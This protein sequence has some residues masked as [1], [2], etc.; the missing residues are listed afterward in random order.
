MSAISKVSGNAVTAT[1]DALAAK[2]AAAKA[3]EAKDTPSAMQD[4]SV[5]SKEVVAEKVA[6]TVEASNATKSASIK[7]DSVQI[8]EEAKSANNNTDTFNKSAAS[9]KEEAATKAEAAKSAT[10]GGTTQVNGDAVKAEKAKR[11][12]RSKRARIAKAS[13][14]SR[15][16]K[17]ARASKAERAAKTGTAAKAVKADRAERAAKAEKAEKA[18]GTRHGRKVE[19]TSKQISAAEKVNHRD[20]S[21]RAEKNDASTLKAKTE[22]L[23]M[24][25][26]G[27]SKMGVSSK[28]VSKVIKTANRNMNERLGKELKQAYSDYKEK[29]I[30][31]DEF[32]S[33]LYGAAIKKVQGIASA[34]RGAYSDR[35]GSAGNNNRSMTPSFGSKESSATTQAPRQ[36][37]FAKKDDAPATQAPQKSIFEKTD[38]AKS[39]PSQLE[40]T[41]AKK[42]EPTLVEEAIAANKEKS[43]EAKAAAEKDE[44]TKMAAKPA[45]E[46]EPKINEKAEVKAKD[47]D[48]D[49]DNKVAKANEKVVPPGLEKKEELPPGQEKKEDALSKLE[50]ELKKMLEDIVKQA[51]KVPPGL[52]KKDELP[53]NA[54][55]AF[56]EIVGMFNDI[57]KMV[58]GLDQEVEDA[59][60]KSGLGE[61]V[62]GLKEMF[63]SGAG[64]EG[65][66]FLKNLHK[67]ADEHGAS[68][69]HEV[70]MA[71]IKAET[72]SG[73]LKGGSANSD[74]GIN[75]IGDSGDG[76]G[77]FSAVNF[78]SELSNNV[79]DGLDSYKD[80]K[81]AR[82]AAGENQASAAG[83]EADLSALA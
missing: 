21:K 59:D 32:K 42:D 80:A 24:A 38:D 36:S 81:E 22:K 49:D 1:K 28:D 27:L 41:Q 48:D 25:F 44:K 63:G 15:A 74:F 50:K 31:G 76:S 13:K 60:E 53:G 10:K 26:K 5:K 2:L 64:V 43:E 35:M 9:T 47:D 4:A 16:T 20:R 7:L 45:I 79:E 37:I 69:A 65:N 54:D 19:K 82:E 29:K 3:A 71:T 51:E 23:S 70:G 52:A 56:E 11:A 66:S 68:A 61:F 34:L 14:A 75:R 12:A 83:V 46:A 72:L 78:M 33:K 73:L 55:K 67:V 6:N 30:S 57:D 58:N 62:S 17:A 39:S 40:K 18:H 77:N 8:S